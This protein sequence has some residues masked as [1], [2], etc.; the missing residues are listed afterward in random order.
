MDEQRESMSVHIRNMSRGL[1]FM[2]MS[3]AFKTVFTSL[4]SL[5]LPVPDA[6]VWQFNDYSRAIFKCI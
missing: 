6:G 1:E 4:S 5:F 3:S 2:I